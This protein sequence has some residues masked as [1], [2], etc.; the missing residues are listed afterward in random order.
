MGTYLPVV[1]F[2]RKQSCSDTRTLLEEHQKI[3]FPGEVRTSGYFMT[4]NYFINRKFTI[5][6]SHTAP[7]ESATYLFSTS[8]FFLMKIITSNVIVIT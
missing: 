7:I 5:K 3:V 1:K 6:I 4:E 2:L 8:C